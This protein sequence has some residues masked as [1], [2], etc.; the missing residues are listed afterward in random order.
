M[1]KWPNSVS[2]L[3]DCVTSSHQLTHTHTHT[4]A[5]V[6]PFAVCHCMLH[7]SR[8]FI[9]REY[10]NDF[11]SCIT[12]NWPFVVRSFQFVRFSS[13]KTRFSSVI[14]FICALRNK[15]EIQFD[16]YR[17]HRSPRVRMTRSLCA[18]KQVDDFNLTSNSIQKT[19][20]ET[21]KYIMSL[22]RRKDIRN[23]I[24]TI[25]Q[26]IFTSIQFY[27][28]KSETA[29]RRMKKMKRQNRII[30]SRRSARTSMAKFILSFRKKKMEKNKKRNLE[31]SRSLGL[32]LLCV[33]QRLK[34]HGMCCR[35]IESKSSV[36]CRWLR[37]H[38]H[39]AP[40]AFLIASSAHSKHIDDGQTDERKMLKDLWIIEMNGFWNRFDVKRPQNDKRRH[41]APSF[42]SLQNVKNGNWNAEKR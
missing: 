12:C 16:I 8:R 9:S 18:R 20:N 37:A 30:F 29:K 35:C 32:P 21:K 14:Y 42:S 17:R 7:F 13:S 11:S 24:S 2:F 6:S 25:N 31:W 38:S 36:Q 5:H 41:F 26:T 22:C 1:E 10:C 4:G 40:I 19:T 28:R 15:K 3:S 27:G 39:K 33:L 23:S 34:F